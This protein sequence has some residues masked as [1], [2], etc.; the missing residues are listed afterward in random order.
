M[1]HIQY[2]DSSFIQIFQKYQNIYLNYCYFLYG[3]LHYSGIIV[4]IILFLEVAPYIFLKL[5]IAV[6][7]VIKA[8]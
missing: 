2:S 5:Y 8:Q 4:K 3:V 1:P 6:T 7:I